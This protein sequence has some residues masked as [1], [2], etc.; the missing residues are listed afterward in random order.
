MSPQS[1]NGHPKKVN[2]GLP[3]PGLINDLLEKSA[4]KRGNLIPVLQGT[5]DVY[6]YL[7]ANVLRVIS[8][9]TG[10]SVSTIYG[11]ASFY[12]QFRFQPVGKYM[13]RV[14]HGTACH[15]QNANAIEQALQDELKIDDGCTTE[16]HLF[17]LETVA[18]LGCCSLAP[19]MMI[20]EEA[21][22]NLTPETAVKII[23]SIRRREGGTV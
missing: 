5:Q 15:V 3:D 2:Q 10:Y 17:T 20:G 4:G 1:K 23:R 19:V 9:R 8:D 21:H 22:G 14:C 7:P 16:D 11:V 12:S 6:G 18:C 13:V